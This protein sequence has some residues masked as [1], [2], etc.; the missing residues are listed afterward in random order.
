MRTKLIIALGILGFSLGLASQDASAHGPRGRVGV[1]VHIGVPGPFYWGPRYYYGGPG[2]YYPPY[3]YS[4]PVVV[5]SPPVYI[6]RG[7][8][9]QAAPAP[10]AAGDWYFCASPEGYYPYVTQCPGG[11]RKVP[12]QP[13]VQPPANTPQ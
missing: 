5:E 12:A 13:P 11:W 4:A 10:Q 2:Y 1:G 8:N 9:E 3:Y 7:A 6:E